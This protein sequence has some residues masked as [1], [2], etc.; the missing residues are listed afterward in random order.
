MSSFDYSAP[1]ELFLFKP[2]KGSHT[3][4]RRFTTAAEAL[5][6]AVED[7]R[8]PKAFGA[9]LEVGDERFDTSESNASMKPMIIRCGSPRTSKKPSKPLGVLKRWETWI[10]PKSLTQNIARHL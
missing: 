6:Y 8:T 2:A 4:Y 1:A 3:K 5:R 9:H 7:L 10:S